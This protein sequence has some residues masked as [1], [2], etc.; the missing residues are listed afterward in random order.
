MKGVGG[1]AWGQA[2]LRYPELMLIRQ[3]TDRSPRLGEHEGEGAKAEAGS[4]LQRRVTAKHCLLK[5]ETEMTLLCT[6]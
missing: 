1:L 4:L 2:G 6:W 5:Q 3:P